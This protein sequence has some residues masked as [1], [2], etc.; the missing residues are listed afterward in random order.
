MANPMLIMYERFYIFCAKAQFVSLVTGIGS[1][2]GKNMRNNNT[3][4]EAILPFK[5][6]K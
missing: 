4:Q 6:I 2:V 5:N 1:K 3:K